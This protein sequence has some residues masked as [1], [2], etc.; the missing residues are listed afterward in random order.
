MDTELQILHAAMDNGI[1]GVFP[2]I[3]RVV[4]SV[5]ETQGLE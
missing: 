1:R 5:N 4:L 3:S 2:G